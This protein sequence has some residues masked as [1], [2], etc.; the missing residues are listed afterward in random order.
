MIVAAPVAGTTVPLAEVNDKVFASGAM[1]QGV[2]ILPDNGRIVAPVAGTVIAATRTGHAF[3]I[4]SDDGVEVL[5]H[6]GIDTVQMKGEGFSP[7]VTRGQRVE[8]GDLLAEVDLD[9]VQKAGFDPTVVT[10][11]T[12]SASLGAVDAVTG[13]SLAAGDAALLIMA[14]APQPVNA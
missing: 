10:I 2:G 12:N 7:K 13:R 4:K 5:V 11:V 14:G 6:V 9:A 8:Q 1:G 3:G